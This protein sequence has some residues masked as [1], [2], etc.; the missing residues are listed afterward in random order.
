MIFLEK[1][2]GWTILERTTVAALFCRY[3]LRFP[4]IEPKD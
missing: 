4:M 1:T 2:G 3:F